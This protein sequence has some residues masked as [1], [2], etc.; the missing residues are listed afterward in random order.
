MMTFTWA[1]KDAEC[2][3]GQAGD[4]SCSLWG[5]REGAIAQMEMQS[6]GPV[7]AAWWQPPQ[8]K[9]PWHFCS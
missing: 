5:G 1:W 6:C 3:V 8:A 7:F 2:T 9:C 4:S